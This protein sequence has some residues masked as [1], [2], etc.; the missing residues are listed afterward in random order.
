MSQEWHILGLESWPSQI[1]KPFLTRIY[2]DDSCF[3]L[4]NNKKPQRGGRKGTF[5]AGVSSGAK[6]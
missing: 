6:F 5:S 3:L 4:Q 1:K 2:K